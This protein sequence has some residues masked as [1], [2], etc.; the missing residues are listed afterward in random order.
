MGYY[1][2]RYI[3]FFIN[4]FNGKCN[5]HFGHLKSKSHSFK[6]ITFID[7]CMCVPIYLYAYHIRAELVEGR[8]GCQIPCQACHERPGVGAGS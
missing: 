7:V 6:K 8:C 3:Q 1:I 4:M 5:T 2:N